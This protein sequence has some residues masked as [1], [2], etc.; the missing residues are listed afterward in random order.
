PEPEPVPQ[1]AE[2]PQAEPPNRTELAKRALALHD[3][4]RYDESFFALSEA[5]AAYPEVAPFLRLRIIEAEIARGN[6]GNAAVIAEEVIAGDHGSASTVARLRLPAIYARAGN[7]AAATD[8]AWQEAMQIPIDELTEPDFIQMANDLAKA[9]R[10]DLATKTRIRLLTDYTSGR[11]TEQMYDLVKSELAQLPVAEKIAL[12]GKL[13]RANRYDQAL[14]LFNMIPGGAP[15]ARARR[16]RALFNSR[17]YATLLEETKEVKLGDP[18]LMLLR[19]RAAWRDDKPQEMLAGLAAIEKEFP[20][21]KEAIEAKVIRA[22]YYVTDE[23]D[24]AKSIENLSQAIAAGAAGNDGENLWNLGFTYTLWGK[25]DEALQTFEQYI[26]SYPDGD[27]KTNSL[28]WSAKIHDKL[29]RTQERDAKA[30]QIIAEYPYSY[31]AYRAKELWA[32]GAATAS[33]T[34]F[35]DVAGELAKITEPRFAVVDALL[36]IGLNRAAAREMKVLAAKYA[37][38]PGVQ[39]LLADVYSRG[40]EPFR[41]NGVLQRNFRQFVRHGGTNIPQRFWE[42]L[43]PLAYWDALQS[44]A[45]RRELDPYL[46]ASITRQESGFEPTTVSNAGAVGLMQIM[47]EEATRIAVAGGLGEVTREQLFDPKTNIAVGAAEYAQKLSIWNGN[48]TLAI[49]SYNA[50]E[51]AVGTWIE[52]TPVHDLDLFVE[53]IPYAETRLYVKT[54]ARNRF[55]YRRIYESNGSRV[56]QHAP[57]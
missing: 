22:K 46:L 23:V 41:A 1:A 50:G 13:S 57:Q 44:E 47:P 54:V 28:F 42:I 45:E 16:L 53:T 26:R 24:Y 9:N 52:K 34:A 20:N 55:E 29:G 8:K 7:A 35:P 31:Y 37:D 49:A 15:E 3:A 56:Q 32:G 27:W 25:Y 51:R 36:D 10:P 30:A 33:Q 6:I 48:H 40:G 12:A 4:K 2:P 11:Y 38:N 14:D 39:F 43:F 17:N 5:A 18:A 19:A 21:S